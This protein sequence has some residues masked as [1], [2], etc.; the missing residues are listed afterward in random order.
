MRRLFC[1]LAL[2]LCACATATSPP[3]PATVAP[4]T[5]QAMPTVHSLDG[6]ELAAVQVPD[7]FRE[8]QEAKLAAAQ[9]A[10]SNDPQ[11]LEAAIDVPGPWVARIAEVAAACR[12]AIT[13][14]VIERE[15]GSCYCTA[16]LFDAKGAL[17]GKHRKLVPTAMERLIWAQ[18]DGSTITVVDNGVG[19]I[20]LNAGRFEADRLKPRFDSVEVGR[21]LVFGAIAI[22]RAEELG[23]VVGSLPVDPWDGAPLEWDEARRTLRSRGVDERSRRL[24][25]TL[26]PQR[27]LSSP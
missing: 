4:S 19:R 6:R 3:T 14:G 9:E 23:E 22:R 2:S 20:L 25:V 7:A 11:D 13:V 24:V 12:M 17:L 21:A 18:G 26:G 5:P 27:G 10:L 15:G 1:L 8:A 16:L